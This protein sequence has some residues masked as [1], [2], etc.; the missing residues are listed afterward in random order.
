VVGAGVAVLGHVGV[1]VGGRHGAVRRALAALAVAR[2]LHGEDLA[3]GLARGA[4]DARG[5]GAVLALGFDARA[6]GGTIAPCA[7]LVGATGELAVRVGEAGVAG[8]AFAA[9][10]A[11]V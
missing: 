7:G 5:A 3:G 8:R 10:T 9:V 6:V 11:A 4:A 2:G 1:V